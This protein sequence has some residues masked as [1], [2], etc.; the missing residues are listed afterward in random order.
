VRLPLVALLE[1]VRRTFL[2]C[3]ILINLLTPWLS[4]ACVRYCL[5]HKAGRAC[6]AACRCTGC[7][8]TGPA[9]ATPEA[10]V[11]RP[12]ALPHAAL[13]KLAVDGSD[14]AGGSLRLPPAG[15]SSAPSPLTQ[16]TPLAVPPAAAFD[17]PSTAS[18]TASPGAEP[19]G[20]AEGTRRGAASELPGLPQRYGDQFGIRPIGGLASSASA[21]RQWIDSGGDF[22]VHAIHAHRH[23]DGHD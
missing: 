16:R 6:T 19:L 11:A 14:A 18:P 1:R 3:L 13:R 4:P 10:G 20:L 15:S 21:M 9:A 12:A 5:C 22:D 8:N 17:P 7:V 2:F 23:T